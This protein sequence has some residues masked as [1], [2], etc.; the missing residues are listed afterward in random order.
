MNGIGPS[1]GG[2]NECLSPGD[3]TIKQVCTLLAGDNVIVVYV[4]G[5]TG[6]PQYFD[7]WVETDAVVPV[8]RQTWG[9]LKVVYR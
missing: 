8:Q 7:G 6:F 5:F 1:T 4:P 9:Q 3:Y 2:N